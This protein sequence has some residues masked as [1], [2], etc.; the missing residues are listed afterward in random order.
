MAADSGHQLPAAER[1]ILVQLAAAGS[2]EPAGS[3][4]HLPWVLNVVAYFTS[5]RSGSI[6]TTYLGDRQASSAASL[7]DRWRQPQHTTSDHL[8]RPTTTT[9]IPNQDAP[10]NDS[11]ETDTSASPG[12]TTSST[13]TASTSSTST[14]HAATPSPPQRTSTAPRPAP[15]TRPEQFGADDQT[16]HH[17]RAAFQ[18]LDEIDLQE[19]LMKKFIGFQSPPTFLKGRIRQAMQFALEAILQ[20]TTADQT[21]RSWKFWLLLPRMLLHRPPG[22]R[23]ISKPDWRLRIAQFQEGEWTALLRQAAAANPQ[24]ANIST[25]PHR[26]SPETP[27]SEQR[28]RRARQLVHQGELSAARH[29]LTAGPLA[30]STDATLQELRD[31][32]RRPPHPYQ[33]FPQHLTEFHPPA[34]PNLPP[35]QLLTNLRKAR[36][37]AA[38]GPSGFTAEILRLVLD[39][40]V[41]SQHF[42]AVATRLAK[43]DIP[44]QVSQAIGLGRVVALQ[45]PNGKVPWHCH[46]RPPP[47]T[48]FPVLGTNVCQPLPLH[49]SWHRSHRPR[50][51]LGHRSPPKPHHTIR[52]R[53]R[54]I[55]HHFPNQ[56]A[57]R[58]TG[59]SRCQQLPPLCAPVLR[60]AIHICLAR[61]QWPTPRNHTSRRR[62]TRRSI[63]AG[64]IFLRTKRSLGSCP[65]QPRR[66][67]RPL[68]YAFLDDVYAVSSPHRV[69][70]I[71]DLLAQHLEARASIRLNSG[72]TRI[73]NT[74][75]HQPANITSLGSEVWVGNMQLPPQQR[76]ITVLGAPVGTREYKQHH[77]QQLQTE[78]NTLLQQLPHLQDLQASWLLLLWCASPRRNHQLR[79]LPPSVTHQFAQDHDVAVAGCLAEMLDCNP[80]PATAL[81]TAHLPLRCGGLGLTSASILATPAYWAYRFWADK[82][83]TKQP[84]SSTSSKARNRRQPSEK[85]QRQPPNSSNMASNH[86]LGTNSSTTNRYLQ[87]HTHMKDPT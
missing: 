46:R 1:A 37:G 33:E 72:K 11:S 75:G 29:A 71:C 28:T 19:T 26:T 50:P 78:H 31:P 23:T 63:D 18:S 41:T 14:S 45:K 66:R 80:P 84:P 64:S 5:N 56:H 4:V 22:I 49:P 6:V 25:D 44:H 52:R 34:P 40:E 17:H 61:H 54:R 82:P 57:R 59:G 43:A 35:T 15:Q 21:L 53:D 36:K 2:F 85:L 48:G 24:R 9:A 74:A 83:R 10:N 87:T 42:V 20:A 58:L 67:R 62:R 79:M 32:A 3:Q 47:Q 60:T 7:A 27:D 77:L 55:R 13:S 39:D 51:H 86:P 68:L 70:A 30:P 16:H 12:D 65:N 76:G 38:P 8:T 69:R 73:W 81:A